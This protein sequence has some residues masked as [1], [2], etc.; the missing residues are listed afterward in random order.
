MFGKY[1]LITINKNPSGQGWEVWGTPHAQTEPYYRKGDY[2]TN[3]PTLRKIQAVA[4]HY[5]MR[6]GC[7][8]IRYRS[9]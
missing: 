7:E 6:V 4:E 9:K 1:K 3:L 5:A 8:I 2:L